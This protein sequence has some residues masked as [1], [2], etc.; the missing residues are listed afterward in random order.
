MTSSNEQFLFDSL[1][2]KTTVT[3]GTKLSA[4]AMTVLMLNHTVLDLENMFLK[5]QLQANFLQEHSVSGDKG[6]I[7]YFMTDFGCDDL[8]Q[9]EL[10]NAQV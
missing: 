10:L 2:N 7:I 4:S 6:S 8:C 5:Y 1:L 9:N 3:P